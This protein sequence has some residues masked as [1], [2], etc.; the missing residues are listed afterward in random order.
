MPP[1]AATHSSTL[2][3]TLRFPNTSLNP[4]D[5]DLAHPKTRVALTEYMRAQQQGPVMHSKAHHQGAQVCQT[6]HQG[7]VWSLCLRS[8][9]NPEQQHAGGSLRAM[10]R[11]PRWPTCSDGTTTPFNSPPLPPTHLLQP[12][13]LHQPLLSQPHPHLLSISTPHT[14]HQPHH[15][16][17]ISTPHTHHQPH[18]STLTT[19]H[20]HHQPQISTHSSESASS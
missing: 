1:C 11:K 8:F 15:Q 9:L 4:P 12:H 20:T 7:P 5:E 18:I 10:Q 3:P 14:H 17:Q 13:T 2:I 6:P 16:P 19:P